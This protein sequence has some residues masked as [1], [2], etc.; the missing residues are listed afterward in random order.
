[1][2]FYQRYTYDKYHQLD[3]SYLYKRVIRDWNRFGFSNPLNGHLDKSRL[4]AY[5]DDTKN[6]V[7]FYHIF[8]EIINPA[9]FI[10]DSIFHPQM[11]RLDFHRSFKIVR[12]SKASKFPSI[13][14]YN[15]RG[16]CTIKKMT[17]KLGMLRVKYFKL[18]RTWK[19]EIL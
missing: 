5:Y 16:K 7:V 13:Y 11:T 17:A 6:I 4:H 2:R 8:M 1:M 15:V 19:N 18:N 12:I 3:S 9:Y 10:N 14:D